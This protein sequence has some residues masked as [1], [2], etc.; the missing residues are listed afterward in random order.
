MKRNT[1]MQDSAGSQSEEEEQAQDIKDLKEDEVVQFVVEKDDQQFDDAIIEQTLDRLRLEFIPHQNPVFHQGQES[2]PVLLQIETKK[3]LEKANRA[4][5]DI[6]C[7]VD[8]SGSMQG[9]KLKLVQQSLRYIQK[10]LSPDDRL[11][12][13]QFSHVGSIVLP[14]TRNLPDNKKTIKTKIQSLRTIGSTNIASG[15]EQGLQLIKERKYKNPVTCMFLLSDG[16]DDD[17]GVEQRVQKLINK[18]Q[19]KDTWVLQSFGYGKD[20]DAKAMDEIA[21]QKL[22]EFRFIENIKLA[23]EHFLLSLS[24]ML[25]LY[26]KD[27][28][29]QL[30]ALQPFSIKTVFG[31]DV[32]WD[33]Q[34]NGTYQMKSNYLINSKLFEHVFEINLPLQYQNAKPQLCLQVQINGYLIG[35]NHYFEKK[36]TLELVIANQVN[37]EFNQQVELQYLKAKAGQSIQQALGLAQ[38]KKYDDAIQ[39][40]NKLLNEIEQ[41]QFNQLDQFKILLDNLKTCK[42]KCRPE[43]YVQ[44]GQAYMRHQVRR[45]CGGQ[46]SISESDGWN[47]E[48]EQV[49]GNL[50]KGKYQLSRSN[51]DISSD[52]DKQP[53]KKQ[54]ILNKQLIRRHSGE[55]N[56]DDSDSQKSPRPLNDVSPRASKFSAQNKKNAKIQKKQRQR[57]ISG[58]GSGSGSG[59]GPNH[60]VRIQTDQQMYISQFKLDHIVEKNNE[61]VV[62]R[63]SKGDQ[64]YMIIQLNKQPL[65]KIQ[66]FSIHFQREMSFLFQ[67]I[68]KPQFISQDF[69]FKLPEQVEQCDFLPQITEIHLDDNHIYFVLNNCLEGQIFNHKIDPSRVFYQVY[70]IFDSYYKAFQENKI[71]DR[72]FNQN[73]L[74]LSGEQ[75]CLIDFGFVYI[76]KQLPRLQWTAKLANLLNQIY[77]NPNCVKNGKAQQLINKLLYNKIIWEDIEQLIQSTFEFTQFDFE[78]Q[79]FKLYRPCR[80]QADGQRRS[81]N[82]TKVMQS[83]IIRLGSNNIQDHFERIKKSFSPG[84]SR[85]LNITYDNKPSMSPNSYQ[86]SKSIYQGSK[87]NSSFNGHFSNGSRQIHAAQNIVQNKVENQFEYKVKQESKERVSLNQRKQYPTPLTIRPQSHKNT[88]EQDNNTTYLPT[89]LEK[90][91]QQQPITQTMREQGRPATSKPPKQ[92]DE[93]NFKSL[94]RSSTK[95]LQQ[96]PKSRKSQQLRNPQQQVNIHLQSLN[97][98]DSSTNDYQFQ[99]KRPPSSRAARRRKSSDSS[100]QNIEQVVQQIKQEQADK[101][102]V[103]T[104]QK[105]KQSLFKRKES[106]EIK[107]EIK[108]EQQQIKPIEQ[109]Q[110]NNQIDNQSQR[111]IESIQLQSNQQEIKPPVQLNIQEIPSLNRNKNDEE[112]FRMYDN[113]LKLFDLIGILVGK[114]IHH[115]NAKKNY[116]IVPLFLCFKRMYFLRKQYMLDFDMKVNLFNCDMNIVNNSKKIQDLAVK[117]KN[118]STIVYNEV[119]QVLKMCQASIKKM[120]AKETQKIEMFINMDEK[121]DVQDVYF[122][123]LYTQIFKTIKGQYSKVE[124]D[125]QKCFDNLKLQLIAISCV[126]I[127]EKVYETHPKYINLKQYNTIQKS[128]NKEEFINYINQLEDTVIELKSRLIQKGIKI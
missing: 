87:Y 81:E 103:Q 49:M 98:N 56:S 21:K 85:K 28:T 105:P 44:E 6:V 45:C 57:S 61:C 65:M 26:A 62:Y 77:Q 106:V 117:M 79:E 104:L 11:A 71:G 36:Q 72:D 102:A 2:I 83:R 94:L 66:Q 33:K 124:D 25:S 50:R 63:S 113:Q 69:I 35:N 46:E 86:G 4:P 52:E 17:K 107:Q 51:S 43:K 1:Y 68:P 128:Q 48:E 22:G 53:Q 67:R 116:W 8:V 42:D 10:I 121:P 70:K 59:Q 127:S 9:E 5:I 7:V 76:Q 23:S 95:E 88:I 126:I 74:F 37:Q 100:I 19:I 29:I 109:T 82:N 112:C 97:I 18:Y 84:L 96:T 54:L 119:E 91:N 114:C 115:F 32:I 123:Y 60:I 90:G 3:G 39:M 16:Q 110:R 118:D 20:H 38:L 111:N 92:E 101:P 122:L 15:V 125:P 89:L 64:K 93:Q 14:W 80:S 99:L 30:S 13:A 34:E 108:E 27:V 47:S 24:S 78:P 120:D 73:R 40:L 75:L 55:F 12:I 31:E 41:S 58:S